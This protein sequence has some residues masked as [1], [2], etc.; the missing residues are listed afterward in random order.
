MKRLGLCVNAKSEWPSADHWLYLRP[1]SARWLAYDLDDYMRVRELPHYVTSV[2][3]INGESSWIGGN[4][5]NAP[6]AAAELRKLYDHGYRPNILEIVNEWDTDI[7][8]VHETLVISAVSSFAETFK[9]TPTNIFCGAV[10]GP[11]WVNRLEEISREFRARHIPISGV[12]LHPYAKRPADWNGN[13]WDTIESAIAT[14]ESVTGYPILISETGISRKDAGGYDGQASWV[15]AMYATVN[16]VKSPAICHFA[17]HD[18]LGM[19]IEQ[20]IAGGFGLI[21]MRG[22]LTPAFREF[23]LVNTR[24]QPTPTPEEPTMPIHN[25]SVGSGVLRKMQENNTT[26]ATCE[27]YYPTLEERRRLGIPPDAPAEYSETMG[28]DNKVYRYVFATNAVVVFP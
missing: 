6:T 3:L 2:I 26:P 25:H 10:A 9:D 23:H 15:R 21:D 27:L 7:F 24:G 12:G 14:A 17:Y 28:M 5:N 19:P 11:D 13:N 8:N 22:E 20:N 1:E 16:R 4:W 18:N